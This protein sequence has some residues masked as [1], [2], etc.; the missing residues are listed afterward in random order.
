M[1]ITCQNGTPAFNPILRSLRNRVAIFPTFC[2][3]ICITPDCCPF[4]IRVAAE[5]V[6]TEALSGIR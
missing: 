6:I 2:G 5:V 1:L 3:R 4:E